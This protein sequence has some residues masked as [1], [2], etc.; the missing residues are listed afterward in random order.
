[1]TT[2][3]NRSAQA[4][5]AWQA[6]GSRRRAAW[7]EVGAGSLGRA[8]FLAIVAGLGLGALEPFAAEAVSRASRPVPAAAATC[9]QESALEP[10]LPPGHPPVPGLRGDLRLPPG[11]PPVGAVPGAALF[12]QDGPRT[13]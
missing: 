2:R 4:R 11:H 1:M 8:L 9:P 3:P 13:L 10:M 5:Q 6:A 12:P 7:R